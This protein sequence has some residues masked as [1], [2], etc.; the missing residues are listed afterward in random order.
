MGGA[1]FGSADIPWMLMTGAKPPPALAVEQIF[2]FYIPMLEMKPIGS[3]ESARPPVKDEFLPH[4]PAPRP[5]AC[6]TGKLRHYA[7]TD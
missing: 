6:K 3:V 5:P 1:A 2:R 4:E 7:H